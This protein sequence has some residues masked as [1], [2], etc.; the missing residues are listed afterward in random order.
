MGPKLNR[1]HIYTP[2]PPTHRVKRKETKHF[3]VL[4]A[5]SPRTQCGLL[6]NAVKRI[7]VC[8]CQYWREI[9]LQS[10]RRISL[11]EVKRH[12]SYLFKPFFLDCR[13]SMIF[14]QQGIVFPIVSSINFPASLGVP[15]LAFR[16]TQLAWHLQPLN[17]MAEKDFGILNSW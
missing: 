2:P 1:A 16:G 8:R 15:Q 14:A 6:K 11:A 13:N 4:L 17:M 12:F 5:L 9:L 3:F 7:R 10:S